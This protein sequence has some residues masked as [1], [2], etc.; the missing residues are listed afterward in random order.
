MRPF[1]LLLA[2][3][4]AA[5]AVLGPSPLIGQTGYDEYLND[6]LDPYTSINR[7]GASR[8]AV[9]PSNPYSTTY[10]PSAA[11][12]AQPGFTQNGGVQQGQAPWS[13]VWWPRKPCELAFMAFSQGLSPLEKYDSL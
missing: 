8:A 2:A 13:G 4:L 9:G 5:T 7:G 1:A 6:D 11:G 10:P 12:P 3:L